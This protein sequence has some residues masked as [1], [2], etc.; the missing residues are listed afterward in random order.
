MDDLKQEFWGD[1]QVDLFTVNSAIYLANTDLK[2]LIG[3]DGKKA[4]K[5]IL[6][7]AQTGIYTP[8]MDIDFKTKRASKSTL[9][10]D[11]FDYAAEEI[12]ITEKLQTPYELVNRSL[13]SI[14]RGLLNIVEQKFLDQIPNAFHSINNNSA[15]ELLPSNVMDMFQEA[16]SKLGA[17]DV[18]VESSMR[19]LVVGPNS[20]SKMR[21]FKSERET[22]LGDSVLGNGV[23]GAWHGWTVVQNNNL[24]YSAIL[25]MDTNPTAGDTVTISGVVFTFRASPSLPGEVDIGNDVATSR[26][27]LKAAVE[28]GAGAGTAYIEIGIMNDTILRKKRGVKCTSAEAMAF[29]GYGDIAV[30]ETFTA[31]TNVWSAQE[32]SSIF[33][34]RG[35]IDM[36]MQFMDLE[37]EKKEKGFADLPKGIIGLGT[38]MFDD[39]ALASVKMTLDASHFGSSNF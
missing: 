32:Q 12:D 1:L 7:N 27:N 35:A 25:T 19:A 14:R 15:F 10:I 29:T 16:D 13:A 24:P 18:P 28:G 4:H 33:M 9:E 31:T 20:V 38:K 21:R 8:H 37:I 6:S 11:T 3:T 34:V 5:P 2:G 17:F 30:S 26:A 39:G 22:G 23:V 36:V